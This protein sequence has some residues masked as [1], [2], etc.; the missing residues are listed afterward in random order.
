MKSLRMLFLLL[1]V[2]QVLLSHSPV[3]SQTLRI[4]VIIPL[5]GGVADLGKTVQ[6]GIELAQ[7]EA[8]PETRNKFELIYEDSKYDAKDSISAFNKLVGNDKIDILWVWGTTPSI[9]LAPLADRKKIP[10]IALSGDPEVAGN[11]TFVIDFTNRLEDVSK[12]KMEY[13]RSQGFNNIAIVKSEIQYLESLLEGMTHHKKGSENID[14][15]ASIPPDNISDLNMILGRLKHSLK[16]K[17]YDALGVFLITGQISTFYTRIPQYNIAIPTF[18]SDFFGDEDEMK[19][20]GSAAV[21]AVFAT[22]TVSDEFTDL[23]L[24]NFGNTTAVAYAANSYDFINL[25]YSLFARSKGEHT[26]EAILEKFESAGPMD[27]AGGKFYF[28]KEDPNKFKNPGKRF[29]YPVTIRKVVEG[30]K[31]IVLR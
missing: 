1:A 3:C 7:S 29:V 15:I 25:I 18:G 11:R 8:D 31:S 12:V 28:L 5:S 4:G 27:G 26:P 21:G 19:K 10:M 30:G 23:Y 20:S 13:L 17:K 22:P 24:K 16:Q 14:V 6:N 2:S 9:A